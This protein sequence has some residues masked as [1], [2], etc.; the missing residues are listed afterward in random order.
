[1]EFHKIVITGGPCGGKTTGMSYI[2]QS[3]T[4]YGYKVVILNESATEIINSRLDFTSCVDNYE[5]E[6]NIIRLQLEKE[7]LYEEACTRLPHDKVILICDRGVMDCKSY[8]SNEDFARILNDLNTS[9]VEL[10]DNYDAVFHLVTAA[11]GAEEYYT[12][13][14]NSARRESLEE[15]KLADDR[16]MW[17]WVGHPHFRAIDNSTTFEQK[18]K[19][20]LNEIL[21][22]LGE[23]EPFEIERKYL[24]KRPD[25]EFLNNLPNAKKIEI[26]QTYLQTSDKT[27]EVRIRQRGEQGNYIYTKTIKKKV[28]PVKRI[29]TERKISERDYL[30]ALTK[31]DT[32]LHQIQKN[33]YCIMHDNHY[34]EIDIY[35]FS[36]EYAICEIELTDEREGF[37]LPNFINVVEEV[38][39]KKGYSNRDLAENYCIPPKKVVR[40]T[41]KET[42]QITLDNL[43]E[44]NIEIEDN[45]NTV[46]NYEDMSTDTSKNTPIKKRNR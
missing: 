18:M 38:T 27:E 24:I 4:K 45:V 44:E 42:G 41:K 35:P 2:E 17:C 25:E 20:L 46:D 16:T 22:Y 43:L 15:A 7:R 10:R 9:E 19:R 26:V 39:G 28:S 36:N 8:T 13:A 29:E 30:E 33:R 23:P 1:M 14:N 21:S 6:K 5:F 31:A 32:K 34:F 3:L 12:L 40:K 37:R 11:K